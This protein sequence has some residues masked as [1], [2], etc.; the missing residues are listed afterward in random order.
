MTPQNLEK[1][2][3]LITGS[4]VASILGLPDAY[5]SAY[6]LF[7]RMKGVIPWQEGND[8]MLAGN[9]AELAIAEWCK[10]KYGWNLVEGPQEGAFH[11]Q[12]PFIYGLVDRLRV[13]SDRQVDSI[14]EFKNQHWSQSEKWENDIP[15]KFKAQGYLYSAIYGLSCQFVACLGGNEYIHYE[16]PRDEDIEGFILQKCCEF[17]DDL[18]NDRW[19]DPDSS[20]SSINTLKHIYKTHSDKMIAGDDEM[21]LCATSYRDARDEEGI[22]KGKKEDFGNRLKSVIAGNLGI[23]FD[24]GQVTWKETKPK[25]EKFDEDSFAAA[26]PAL[27]AQFCK[28]P[29][30]TRRLTVKV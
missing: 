29:E 6:T 21:L 2:K 20:E 8:L 24:G 9:C 16:L 7:A 13:N 27:Y 22:A 18:N 30:S 23:N 25:K 19:P 3:A 10:V 15:E 26:H 28:L 14:I 4:K 1:H 11:P 5:D 12:Y 17:W